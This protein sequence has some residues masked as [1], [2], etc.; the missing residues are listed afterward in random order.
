MTLTL[1]G[2]TDAPAPEPDGRTPGDVP[3]APR[4]R[5]ERPA[6]LGLLA[7]TAVLYVW[8]L[9]SSGWANQFYSAAVQ[10]GSTSWSAFFF[11]S[12]DA[13]GS[14]TVDK[15]PAAL[16]VMDL[17]AR[18][19]GVSSLSI[20]VP[21]ALEGVAAVGLL[22]AAVRRHS[23]AG[24]GL[25]A[26]AVLALTPVATLMFR[27]N[28]PDALLVLLLVGAVYA[29]TRAVETAGTRWLVLAGSLIGLGFLTKMLQAFLLVPVLG[30]VYLLCAPTSLRRRLAQLVAGLVA[31]VVSAG[32]WVAAVALT[33]ASSL[34]YIGGSQTNSVLELTLGYNGLGRLSGNETGSVGGG[35]GGGGWGET[36][37][38]RMFNSEFGS[39][40]SWLVPA[41]LVALGAMLWL[42]R[43]SPRTDGRL[44]GVLLW[45]GWLVVTG[46]T[47]SFAK[48]IIHPYY[49]VALAPAVGALVG[50]GATSWWAR[51]HTLTGRILLALTLVLS[52]CWAYVLLARSASWHP[53]LRVAILVTSVVLA[54]VLLLAP[55]LT[56][57]LGA[58]VAAL[59][60]LVALAGPAASSISTAGTA[61][62]GALP[63]AGP[64]VARTGGPGGGPGIPGGQA[65]PTRPG[66]GR[67]GAGG[68]G[69]GGGGMSG[70][71]GASTPSAELTALLS[72]DSASW[73]WVAATVGANNAA[74]LQLAGGSPVMAIGGFN[75][76]DPSP[77]LAAFQELVAA[78]KIHLFVGSGLSGGGSSSSSTA[79]AI[80]SW[81]SQTFPATT[82]GSTTVYDL[83]SATGAA[84]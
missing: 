28:N 82:V 13:A 68:G 32:W 35:T 75:G 23:G 19:F 11:G 45:G 48:G 9:A 15:P 14:I 46:L 69:M 39:Q 52:A 30:L 73:T 77:T 3:P 56:G 76:T 54:A 59:A 5:W 10:A 21:Q 84:S 70:L 71:L 63:S 66:T 80:V 64:T 41:A 40:I 78:G 34:P 79:T 31:L 60:L 57:R 55:R 72:T 37:L 1:P 8:D 42:L 20:L 53:Q 50:I 33:P 29:V 6:L 67:G 43:R 47:F 62:T 18:L 49:S 65:P 51:R 74:A 81:V 7:A 25:L 2:R 38:L 27:F 44:A 12:L 58:M 83:S 16:W 22:H 17:S 24:A 4:P 36:G 61:H 26:G